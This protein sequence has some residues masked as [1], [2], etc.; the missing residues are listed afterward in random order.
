MN[1]RSVIKV[2]LFIVIPRILSINFFRLN[3]L[4][5]NRK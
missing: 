5:K 1:D 4:N 2:Y 3:K